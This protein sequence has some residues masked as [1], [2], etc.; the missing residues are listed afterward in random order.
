MI[1]EVVPMQPTLV[2]EPFDRRAGSTSA[3]KTA[4]RMVVIKCGC[5]FD[6]QLVSQFHLH[7]DGIEDEPATP[8]LCIL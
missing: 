4:W 7:G 2:R 1:A 6:A 8:P 5:V 3:R